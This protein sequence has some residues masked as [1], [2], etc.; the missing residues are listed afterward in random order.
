MLLQPHTKK[1][2]RLTPEKLAQF[3]WEKYQPKGLENDEE[4]LAANF[5][6]AAE[7]SYLSF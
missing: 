7:N 5:R 3:P 2:Q 6:W 1:G 4:K